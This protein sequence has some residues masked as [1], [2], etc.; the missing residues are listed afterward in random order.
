MYYCYILKSL[1]EK[2]KDSTYIGFT[3]NPIHRLRQHNG[4]IK[5]GAKATSKKR[6]WSLVLVISNFPNKALALKFEWAWQNPYRSTF[7]KQEITSIALPST[8]R[9]KNKKKHILSLPFKLNVLSVLMNTKVFAKIYLYIY[10]FDSTIIDKGYLGLNSFKI[11]EQVN[12]ESFKDAI[13]KK[14][15]NYSKEV[16]INDKNV[17]NEDDDIEMNEG[18]V[19]EYQDK[20]I[21]C[22]EIIHQ[23]TLKQIEEESSNYDKEINYENKDCNKEVGQTQV[24]IQSQINT[25]KESPKSLI[26]CP[27]CK[28]IYHMT[29]LASHTLGDNIALIPKETICIICGRIY[30]WSEW[31]ISVN[32]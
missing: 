32:Y 11:L 25:G 3:D 1:N 24:H 7:I 23:E 12:E 29:C 26:N 17:I 2:S 28:S 14:V 30:I 16:A 15:Y 10:A 20:C 4:L 31:I 6:P 5:G 27:Y 13:Q 22:D 19:I 18:S 21:L 8:I 9:T